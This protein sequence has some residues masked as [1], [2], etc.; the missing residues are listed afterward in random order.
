MNSE[1]D[2]D[3]LGYPATRQA[4][5]ATLQ[6]CVEKL[7][8]T[9][10]HDAEDRLVLGPFD[11]EVDGIEEMIV[12]TALFSFVDRPKNGRRRPIDRIAPRLAVKRDPIK[13]AIVARLPSAVFS[14]FLVERVH[15]QG[16]V[17]ARDLLTDGEPHVRIMDA[18]LAEHV[19][20]RGKIYIAGRF[21][22]LG[23]WLLGF[24][25]I[26]T[27]RKSD[28]VAIRLALSMMADRQ[29]AQQSLHQL[30]Y[31]AEIRRSDLVMGAFEPI[32]MDIALAIDVGAID[33]DDI[34]ADL[35]ILAKGKTASALK[36]LD[37]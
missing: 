7:T 1:V 28:T 27:L 29:S 15:E 30:I 31:S 14:V 20:K 16:G 13:S 26:A 22:D 5:N 35:S 10:V 12:D 25:I 23:P 8:K 6:L 18:S 24:G 11:D 37:H 3:A 34:I 36:R 17:V 19:K 2:F 21:V 33:A 4:F 9:E 32:L